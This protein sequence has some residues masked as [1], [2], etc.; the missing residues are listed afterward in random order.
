MIFLK[1][2]RSYRRFQMAVRG[3]TT[4]AVI[5]IDGSKIVKQK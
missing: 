2:K 4:P 5:S 1:H 3:A